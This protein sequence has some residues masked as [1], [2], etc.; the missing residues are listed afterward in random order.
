MSSYNG[1]LIRLNLTTG[2][3]Q[4]E[5]IPRAWLKDFLGGRGLGVKYLYEEL[6]PGVEP[7]SADNK[8]IIMMGP[9]GATTAMSVSRTALVTKS[10][11]T[12]TIAKSVM[13][14]YFGAFLKFAGY[15]GIIVEG[16]SPK[17]VYLHI[18]KEGLHLHDAA[19][20][21]GLDS[22]ETH[23]KLREKHGQA[24]QVACIGPAGENLVRYA[25]LISNLRVGG[26]TGVGTVLGAKK[27]K[28]F[29]VNSS[30]PLSLHDPE[31]F[32]KLTKEIIEGLRTSPGR[33]KMSDYGTSYLTLGF[34]KV[35]IFPV[36]NFQEGHLE[37][38]EKIGEEALAKIKIK[39]DGCYGCMAKCGQVREVTEGPYAGAISE[40][41][42]YETVWSLG[43][44]LGIADAGALIAAD[45]VCDKLG[46]DTVSAGNTIGFAY[47]LYQRGIITKADTDGLELNWG[48][49]TPMMALLEKIGSRQGFGK[50]LGEGTKRAAAQIGKGAED[51]AI[52]IKGLELPA[53][54]PRAV[55]GYGLILATSNIGASHMYGRPRDELAGKK[56]KLTEVDKGKDAAQAESSQATQDSVIQCSFSPVTGFNAEQRSQLLVAGT[57]FKE[58]GDPDYV[59]K[60]G[61]RT[62]CLERCFNVREGFD[63]KD[64]VLPK[65]MRTEP[66]KNAG[67]A[68]G[69]TFQN[70]DGLLD[71]YYDALGYSRNGIPT[72]AKLKELGLGEVAKD[73]AK[74]NK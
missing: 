40:G 39:N 11:L 7:L 16:E 65:R 23:R 24:T 35:G 37:G 68:T 52:Q 42:D 14:G 48:D 22:Q 58:F 36:K 43:G 71:E 50:L 29:A 72:E 63:R 38:V 25:V 3:S 6:K 54:E 1:K 12:G 70:L 20:L 5:E 27:I 13:G 41:P 26:R 18:D 49:P 30:G 45:A 73:I 56:D 67:P 10:P 69:Q 8:M 33:I 19:D 51:Y 59:E 62:L 66:L 46:M 17:P 57:G 53:Y 21:W 31:A 60:V 2:K 47:E 15:D 44:N 55:K 34:E 28:A 74:F 9:L 4:V 61:E 64:D 32:K